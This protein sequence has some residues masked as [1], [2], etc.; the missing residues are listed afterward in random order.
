MSEEYVG[1][2]F[3]T[4]FLEKKEVTDKR[5]DQ[6]ILWGKKLAELGLSPKYGNGSAGN[7]SFRTKKGFIITGSR[8]NF[9]KIK[10]SD[11]VEVFECD[12][13]K[14]EL[15]A[16]GL[17]EPSSE[18]FLHFSIYKKRRDIN[19]VFHVHDDVVLKSSNII[20][21]EKEQPYG[22]LELVNEVLRVLDNN[23][24]ILMKN[25]GSLALGKTIEETGKL[26]IRRHEEAL[27][28]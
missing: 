26:V 16:I 1:V 22:G 14:K 21:T 7:L 28:Q 4:I 6:L 5:I 12:I 18:S 25:H 2:K 23:D 8:T 19:V 15:Y 27:K 9:S 24:Y 3:K 20:T 11:F 10:E 13:N 17:K